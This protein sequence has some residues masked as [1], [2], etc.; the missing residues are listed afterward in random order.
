MAVGSESN[1]PPSRVI[2]LNFLS[3][4]IP[5]KVRLPNRNLRTG[6]LP[7]DGLDKAFWRTF[8]VKTTKACGTTTTKSVFP[9]ASDATNEGVSTVVF[10]EPMIICLNEDFLF[11]ASV[12]NVLA[13]CTCASLNMM[14]QA[15]SIKNNRAS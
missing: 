15:R 4:D 12:H 11:E 10:P 6:R 5:M 8:R 13:V 14:S 9:S 3:R 2:A 1:T 7:S